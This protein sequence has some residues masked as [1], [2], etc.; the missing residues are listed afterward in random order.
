MRYLWVEAVPHLR[1]VVRAYA[2]HVHLPDLQL[3]ARTELGR[4]RQVAIRSWNTVRRWRRGKAAA[5][6]QRQ[7]R[8]RAASGQ[9]SPP[10][11]LIE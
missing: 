2:N 5:P 6:V 4:Q 10:S 7:M 1:K 3:I 11:V 8:R 9:L